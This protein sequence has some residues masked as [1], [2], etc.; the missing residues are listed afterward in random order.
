MNSTPWRIVLDIGFA[1]LLAGCAGW[2]GRHFLR[3]AVEP[4]KLVLRWIL[5]AALITVETLLIHGAHDW[6]VALLILPAAIIMGVIWT[7][8]VG[9]IVGNL[10]TNAIDGGDVPMEAQPF[11]SIA[12]AKRRNGH[13]LEAV[14]AVREQLAKFPGDFHGAMLLA[15]I[16]AEDMNDLPG[17]QVALERWMAGP[18]ATPQGMASALTALADWHLQLAQD[19]DAARAALERIVK[20]LPDTPIAHRA[21]QRLAHLPTAE[22][23]MSARTPTV[24][25]LPEREKNIGL[26]KD[27]KDYKGPSPPKEDPDAL[28]DEWVQQLQKY[29]ADTATREKL[30]VLYA[31]HFH[32]LDLAVDQLEQLIAFPHETPRNIVHWLNL[33]ADLQIRCGKDPAAAELALRRIIERFPSPALSEPAMARL[34]SLEGEMKAGRQTAVKPMGHYEKYIGLKKV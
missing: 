31:D 24:L 6:T 1:L 27:F 34:A 19:R 28:V 32:R 20:A 22:F 21:A 23:L 13:P 15:S 17:A 16:L 33:L 8:S 26:L 14:A 5:S 25:N 7:P 2:V 12:E 29:P 11:Y 3:K 18:G 9:A 10:L 30:A 4:A